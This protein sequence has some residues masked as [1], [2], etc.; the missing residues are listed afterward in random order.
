[1]PAGKQGKK[2]FF[3]T[4]KKKDQKAI[5]I[6]Y[7]RKIAK[8]NTPLPIKKKKLRIHYGIK[9]DFSFSAKDTGECYKFII[10]LIKMIVLAYNIS[11]ICN[12]FCISLGL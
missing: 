1:M 5:I 7:A 6:Y 8:Y 4:R 11:N 3:K 12:H 9:A 2:A 10:G